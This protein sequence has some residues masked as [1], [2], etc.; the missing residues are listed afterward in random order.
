MSEQSYERVQQSYGRC[1]IS[2]GF[3]D[4]FYKK[5][6]DSN[7]EIKKMFENTDMTQQK[8]LVRHGLSFVIQF[9]SDSSIAKNK[10]KDLR[11]SHAA[12]AMDIPKWMYQNWLN[13]LLE[14]VRSHDKSIDTITLKD[15]KVVLQKGIAQISGE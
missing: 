6:M 7:S 1:I 11:K 2:N 5:F 3:F 9:S 13:S 14:T 4:D 8:K 12:D 10:M 15:W